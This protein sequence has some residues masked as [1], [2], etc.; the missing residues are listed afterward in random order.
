VHRTAPPSRNVH[1][2]GGTTAQ[3][4]S[5]SPRAAA[6]QRSARS[7]HASPVHR[8][9]APGPTLAASRGGGTRRTGTARTRQ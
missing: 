9:R 3:R 5:P 1:Q 6:H 2:R 7:S 8:G 4:T